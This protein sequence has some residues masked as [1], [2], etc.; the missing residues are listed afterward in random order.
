MKFDF[1]TPFAA[2]TICSLQFVTCKNCSVNIVNVVEPVNWLNSAFYGSS[3]GSVFT[4]SDNKTQEKY[5]V[6]YTGVIK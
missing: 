3:T 1:F 4:R 5:M 6:Q 2:L